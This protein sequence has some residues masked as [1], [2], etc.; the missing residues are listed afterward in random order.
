MSFNYLFYYGIDN[1]HTD[2]TPI[3]AQKC[4]L[5]SKQHALIP[6]GYQNLTALFGD[7]FPGQI[8][9]IYI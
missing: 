5:E 2:I 9:Y 1:N 6:A 4:I 3:V 7:P 8:K